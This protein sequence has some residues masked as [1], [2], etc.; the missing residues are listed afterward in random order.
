[1]KTATKFAL[2]KL[3]VVLV[4]AGPKAVVAILLAIHVIVLAMFAVPMVN[5]VAISSAS[6]LGHLAWSQLSTPGPP[7]PAG[8]ITIKL[9]RIWW[10]HVRE[11][12]IPRLVKFASESVGA[13]V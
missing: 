4:S 1:M 12:E 6:S 13:A 11:V 5:T 7:T 10:N 8:D 2:R 9:I 3:N